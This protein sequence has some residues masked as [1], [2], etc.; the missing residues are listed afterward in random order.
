MLD[1]LLCRRLEKRLSGVRI[2]DL[3]D[4]D[5]A[6]ARAARSPAALYDVVEVRPAGI[7]PA[8]DVAD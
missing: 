3:A 4:L 2:V 8:R 1:R 6:I 5:A 7:L